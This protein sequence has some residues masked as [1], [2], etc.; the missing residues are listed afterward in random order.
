MEFP[1]R[2]F[3]QYKWPENFIIT[4]KTKVKKSILNNFFFNIEIIYLKRVVIDFKQKK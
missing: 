4:S 2:L 3:E 1:S